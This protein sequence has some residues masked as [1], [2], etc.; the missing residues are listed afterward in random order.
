MAAAEHAA[1]KEDVGFEVALLARDLAA[2]SARLGSLITQEGRTDEQSVVDACKEAASRCQLLTAT[3]VKLCNQSTSNTGALPERLCKVCV[4]LLRFGVLFSVFFCAVVA[5]VALTRFVLHLQ[6]QAKLVELVEA[7]KRAFFN[8]FDIV[9]SQEV[10]ACCQ[11]LERAVTKLCAAASFAR[12]ASSVAPPPPP[13]S[14]SPTGSASSPPTPGR[15]L[16]QQAG[17]IAQ[18]CVA[19]F[20]AVRSAVDPAAAASSQTEDGRQAAYVAALRIFVA[21][22]NGAVAF[23]E[24]ASLGLEQHLRAVAMRVGVLSKAAFLT[25]NDAAHQQELALAGRDVSH[26]MMSLL[27]VCGDVAPSEHDFF[28]SSQSSPPPPPPPPSSSTSPPSLSPPPP[29]MPL[30]VPPP[31]RPLPTPVALSATPKSQSAPRLHPPPPQAPGPKPL[32]HGRPSTEII[33]MLRAAFPAFAAEFSSSDETKVNQI[34][35]V[36]DE[37]VL[38]TIPPPSSPPPPVGTQP[39]PP[40]G[41]RLPAVTSRPAQAGHVQPSSGGRLARS[42][43]NPPVPATAVAA[44]AANESSTALASVSTMRS[45]SSLQLPPTRPATVWSPHKSEPGSPTRQLTS[46][47]LP[48]SLEELFSNAE[49]NLR[50]LVCA[51]RC[52]VAGKSQELPPTIVTTI[53]SSLCALVEGL[54]KHCVVQVPRCTSIVKGFAA[55]EG[56]MHQ[57]TFSEDFDGQPTTLTKCEFLGVSLLERALVNAKKSIAPPADTAAAAAT[58][59][60]RPDAAVIA[61]AVGRDAKRVLAMTAQSVL[62]GAAHSETL[63]RHLRNVVLKLLEDNCVSDIQTT[64]SLCLEGIGA[65]IALALCAQSFAT[66][67]ETLRCITNSQQRSP[68]SFEE[69]DAELQKVAPS[70]AVQPLVSIWHENAQPLFEEG[71]AA[72]AAAALKA[73][74]LNHIVQRV[75]SDQSYDNHF[76]FTL[77]TMHKSFCTSQE[78]FSKLVER[79][80]VPPGAVASNRIAAIRLK[81]GIVIKYWVESQFADFDQ[82]L[83]AELRKLMEDMKRD[84]H[85]SLVAALEEEIRRQKDA[86]V[87]LQR[88]QQQQAA[89]A[90]ATTLVPTPQDATETCGELF[91]EASEADVAAQFTLID[92]ELF[93]AIK[94]SELVNQNWSK[95]STRHE[96]PTVLSIIARYNTV[97]LWVA[98][99]VLSQLV[100][101]QRAKT[102]TKFILIADHLR[103]MQNFNSM[104]GIIAGLTQASVARLTHTWGA[105]KAPHLALF[106]QLQDVMSP[107]GSFK[108]YRD[109]LSKLSGFT[110]PYLGT[111]LSDLT[112]MGDGNPDTV[113]GVSVGTKLINF[114]KRELIYGVISQLRM[115]VQGKLDIAPKEPLRSALVALPHCVDDVLY[116]VSIQLEPRNSRRSELV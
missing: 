57:Q 48:T 111:Y 30:P 96:S 77:I 84:G 31:S 69:V 86:E 67:A 24:E 12:S 103:R 101:A 41:P 34:L 89:A 4:P 26:V 11:A 63:H 92:A 25:P 6:T 28:V 102:V 56:L 46:P 10:A 94:P 93:R 8:P 45:L 39:V 23:S 78:L 105:V 19:A 79:Y 115:H 70:G 18:D 88:Q 81:V 53:R 37:V 14:S 80:H 64:F 83:L 74:T 38:C 62:R 15:P 27:A 116:D 59:Q 17:A 100:V 61:A 73:G 1:P 90:M 71:T 109:A 29:Q 44:T 114:K 98:T 50:R 68:A 65:A 52:I 16:R 49:D 40:A 20:R 22:F 47:R 106:E 104:M 42:K 13:P 99:T 108:N 35:A 33:N 32:Q 75:T 113:D 9:A 5:V 36:I 91:A 54:V 58:G 60:L 76:L 95:K 112:F 85:G 82:W 110:L 43:S 21:A 2:A 87:A 7:V 97:A 72:G 3:V 66:T 107:T 55:R 51:S